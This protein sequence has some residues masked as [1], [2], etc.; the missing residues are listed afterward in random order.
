MNVRDAWVGGLLF[1]ALAGCGGNVVVS[2][3]GGAGGS[4]SSSSSS[5][6]GPSCAD[7]CPDGEVCVGGKCAQSC[8]GFTPCAQGLVCNTCATSSCPT[9]DDCVGAC[10]PAKPGECDDHDD[11]AMG[12]VC[13]YG[14]GQCA[15]ACSLVPPECPT[16]DLVCN[17]C[18]TAPC[19]GCEACLGACT[20]SF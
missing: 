14:S 4:A 8:D 11:C 12:M 2:G 3:S 7:G 17:P 18:A 10:E 16:P 19:P 6:G 13:I 20:E 15:P 9:C 5:S 1:V